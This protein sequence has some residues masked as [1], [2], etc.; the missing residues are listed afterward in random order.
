MPEGADGERMLLARS[1]T[2]WILAVPESLEE[3]TKALTGVLH[4]T[5]DGHWT[6]EEAVDRLNEITTQWPELLDAHLAKANMLE[7]V[8]EQSRSDK[9][10]EDAFTI[11]RRLIGNRRLRLKWKHP[12][13]RPFLIA[14]KGMVRIRE[15]Q[16][17]EYAAVELMQT[18]LGWC[19]TDELNVRY[20]L[21]PALLRSGR[22]DEAIEELEKDR[23][24]DAGNQYDY[25]LAMF[26]RK[27]YDEAA[28][29][30]RKAFAMNTDI[31]DAIVHSG[32]PELGRARWT[33]GEDEDRGKAWE[34]REKQGGLWNASL[35]ARKFLRYVQTHPLVRNEQAQ[36][37]LEATACGEPGGDTSPRNADQELAR[38]VGEMDE[39]M[40]KILVEETIDEVGET[41]RPWLLV[42]A[43]E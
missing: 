4:A 5:S 14:A 8:D 33:S 30:L 34:Y 9:A 10:K 26:G 35:E 20:E 42:R 6:A 19:P 13:N 40:S 2:D 22:H 23:H 28:T 31:A 24:A 15:R 12:E 16:G 38:L 43:Y 41:V 37:I 11:G 27:R 25:A 36:L 18:I 21:G 17:R 3:A 32:L 7:E 29:A 1:G 39:S